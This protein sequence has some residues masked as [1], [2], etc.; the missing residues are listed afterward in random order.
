MPVVDF[1]EYSL[2][3]YGEAGSFAVFVDLDEVLEFE[4]VIEAHVSLHKTDFA[5]NSLHLWKIS[6]T[7][8]AVRFVET[9]L[10]DGGI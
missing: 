7:D 2:I 9:E 3:W 5:G 10:Y 6:S 8:K 4:N 1:A